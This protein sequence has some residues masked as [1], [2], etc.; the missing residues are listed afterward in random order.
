M[1][2]KPTGLLLSSGMEASPQVQRTRSVGPIGTA[3]TG[4]PVKDCPCD[5]C[6]RFGDCKADPVDS[7]GCAVFR[8]WVGR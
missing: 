1:K 8:K 4:N 7:N 2:A 3:H 5:G 6:D